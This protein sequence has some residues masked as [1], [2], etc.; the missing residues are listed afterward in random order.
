MT[1]E[2]ARRAYNGN[3]D[4]EVRD[5]VRAGFQRWLDEGETLEAALGV[6][7]PRRVKARNEALRHAALLV[8]G[9]SPWAQACALEKAIER[10]EMRTLQMWR[11]HGRPE[12]PGALNEALETAF[13]AGARVPKTARK[14][15]EI[16]C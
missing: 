14:L 6:D 3:F 4:R 5:W 11:R 9:V 13:L 12:E 2:L 8:G 1:F 16:L 15:Y 10:F 7:R